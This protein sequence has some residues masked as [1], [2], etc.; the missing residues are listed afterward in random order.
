LVS[1]GALRERSACFL[2]ALLAFAAGVAAPASA[3]FVGHGAPVRDIVTSSDGTLA[4]T[5]GFDDQI[6]VWDVATREPVH[7]LIGHEAGVNA[8]VFLPPSEQHAVSVGDDASVR[9]WDL[10][11]GKELG[12][13]NGHEKK[14]V[15][16]A[17]SSDGR[18]A[19]SASWDRTVRLWEVPGGKLLRVFEG[20]ENN[21]NAVAFLPG[22]E[23]LLSAGY[24]GA[25]W[26]WPLEETA[27]PSRL[28]SV[29]FPINDLA[30]SA[31]GRR[32]VTG[33]ADGILRL[34][35]LET[36]EEIKTFEGH[37]G[38]VLAVGLSPDGRIIAS[39]GTDGKLMLWPAEDGEAAMSLEVEHYSAVWSIDF[40]PQGAIVYAGGVD[41]VA[42][43]W[44]VA[45]GEPVLGSTTAFQPIARAAPGAAESE[46]PVERGSYHFRKCAVCHSLQD[47]GV[48]RA[49]PSLQ[50]L[51]GRRV[52]TYPGY[53]YSKALSESALV[54]TEETVSQ[55]F[56]L[57]PD[58]L[59]PGTKMPLQRL[60]DEQARDDLIVFLKKFTGSP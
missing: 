60:P 47:D 30:V 13:W 55:L 22:D 35:D 31:D 16:V 42:R 59:L 46:D 58:V 19:A 29:G 25:I 41:P 9:I 51:F 34:W 26:Y 6:I 43:A 57:G 15:S 5:A 44:F 32:F 3:D 49:G 33:S 39:G 10:R 54:W 36:R 4:L 1:Y 24:D 17:V 7:R 53:R 37:G 8:A 21:V 18:L 14:V 11:E 12:R 27:S 20:H 48:P 50:G 52:G 56:D 23:A 45:T 28:A 40:S 2:L 38:A